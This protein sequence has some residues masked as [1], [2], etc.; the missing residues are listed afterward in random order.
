MQ[1]PPETGTNKEKN[2]TKRNPEQA[3]IKEKTTP[4]EIRNRHQ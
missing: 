3:P 4:K 2:D 1:E